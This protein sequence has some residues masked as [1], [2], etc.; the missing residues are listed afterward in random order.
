LSS[1]PPN[2]TDPSQNNSTIQSMRTAIDAKNT[3]LAA[4]RQAREAAEARALELEREKLTEAERLRLESEEKDR[5]IAELSGQA[6]E[7]ATAAA[8]LQ[9]LYDA[10]LA[11]APEDKR[12]VLQRASSAG[13]LPERIR[14]LQAA[15]SLI[16]TQEPNVQIVG[17][18]TN[19]SGQVPSS[20]SATPVA[21]EQQP[22]DPKQGPPGWNR[23]LSQPVTK[24]AAP[25]A[26]APTT[27][28]A[29]K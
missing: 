5:K 3:E 11:S 6:A 27:P 2:T 22:W 12:E 18:I 24:S 9:E 8:T 28:P 10:E 25:A 16:G 20:T 15:K 14:A 13:S 4:E 26:P 23:A 29:A 7:A 1:V 17:T 19:P 21:G